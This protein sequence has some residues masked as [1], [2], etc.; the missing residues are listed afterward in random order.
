MTTRRER[1]AGVH[2]LVDMLVEEV[3]LVDRAANK[4][5]FLVV[6][7]NGRMTTESKDSQAQPAEDEQNKEKKPA[8]KADA[9]PIAIATSALEA[10]TIQVE[11]LT[12]ANEGDVPELV[13]QLVEE[14]TEAATDL[15]EAVGMEGDSGENE[16]GKTVQDMRACVKQVRAMIA[17][18]AQKNAEGGA[19]GVSGQGT[20]QEPAE[21]VAAAS[22]DPAMQLMGKI[23]EQ[24]GVVANTLTNLTDAVK[25]QAQR[26][27]K[28]EKGVG[29]PNSRNAPE[30]ASSR[31]DDEV[32]WPLDM[33]RPTDRVN[34]EKG[35]SIHSLRRR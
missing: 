24:L 7:R 18:A 27:G 1:K 12:E 33:N 11:R 15:A 23:T 2:R 3:S 20:T 13:A 32:S 16:V 4:H 10:I 35:M 19:S 26:L 17:Q 22:T 21:A 5:R 9:D 28:V 30:R 34:A 29:I 31:D 25:D 6:K 14:L 8:S